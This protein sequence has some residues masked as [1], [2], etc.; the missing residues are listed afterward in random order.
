[1]I[2]VPHFCN[3]PLQISAATAAGQAGG[4]GLKTPPIGAG[5]VRKANTPPPPRAQ[6]IG[7]NRIRFGHSLGTVGPCHS[8]VSTIGGSGSLCILNY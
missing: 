6:F 7:C 2:F 5:Q 1:M 4:E 3:L 8:V